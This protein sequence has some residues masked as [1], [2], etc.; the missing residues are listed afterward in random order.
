MCAPWFGPFVAATVCDPGSLRESMAKSELDDDIP[1]GLAGASL[2]VVSAKGITQAM[3]EQLDIDSTLTI[4]QPVR[5]STRIFVRGQDGASAMFTGIRAVAG[6]KVRYAPDGGGLEAVA[7]GGKRYAPA[8]AT[9]GSRTVT[10][11]KAKLSR[12]VVRVSYRTSQAKSNV[13]LLSARGRV[14]LRKTVVGHGGAVRTR[15]RVPRGVH[16]RGVRIEGAGLRPSA[17]RVG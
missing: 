15:V 12:G 11:L 9:S 6:L 16:I 4:R 5:G 1:S 14:V 8:T 3:G 17:R 7:P 2:S 13:V 10:R